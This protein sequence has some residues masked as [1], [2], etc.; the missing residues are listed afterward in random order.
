MRPMTSVIAVVLTSI[1]ISVGYISGE[2]NSIVKRVSYHDCIV[3]SDTGKNIVYS[4][5]EG[6]IYI[7]KKR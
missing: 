5:P 7:V 2:N 6:I 1:V 4:C 3:I